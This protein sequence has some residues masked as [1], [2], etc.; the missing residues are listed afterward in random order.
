MST[1]VSYAEAVTEF[2]K[3][4]GFKTIGSVKELT[5]G[6]QDGLFSGSSNPF[7]TKMREL[8][9]Y[10]RTSTTSVGAGAYGTIMLGEGKTVFKEID[11]T[12]NTTMAD[13]TIVNG[14]YDPAKLDRSLRKVF[15]EA[16]IQTVLGLDATVGSNIAEILGV[17]KRASSSPYND[18]FTIIVIEMKLL[19]DRVDDYI[20]PV[21]P[22][23]FS[24]IQ[25]SVINL[26]EILQHL[27]RAYGF[28]H[29]DLHANN[30]MFNGRRITLIDFGLSCFTFLNSKGQTVKYAAPG[31][32]NKG[33]CQSFDMY[34][35]L[36]SLLHPI[37]R[38]YLSEACIEKIKSFFDVVTPY[39]GKVVNLFDTANVDP[40]KNSVFH[41]FYEWHIRDLLSFIP[42]AEQSPAAHLANILGLVSG[43]AGVTL[44][45]VASGASNSASASSVTASTVGKVTAAELAA[46]GPITSAY[47]CEGGCFMRWWGLRGGK[48][49]RRYKKRGRT[50]KR[51]RS[52]F[53]H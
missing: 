6:L 1:K 38:Q 51:R 9:V 2:K 36:A 3:I 16:W 37:S 26:I 50:Q 25:D 41:H 35:F 8:R 24:Y 14:T 19:G 40:F 52:T 29:R 53:R 22:I 39:G 13:G 44:T 47:G 5:D 7:I 15:F 42:A 21:A 28:V 27:N 33:A 23:E 12:G 18:K 31:S 45:G 32:T 49:R 10:S 20:K 17:Y 11:I 43:T 34:I 48:T 4:L 30:V 46:S